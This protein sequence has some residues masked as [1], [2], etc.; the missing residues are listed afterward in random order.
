[1]GRARPPGGRLARTGRVGG[2]SLA[3]LPIRAG[4]AVPALI[5]TSLA[6]LGIVRLLPVEGVGLWLRLLVATVVALL[7]G[8][9]IGRAIGERGLAGATV[10]SVVAI[11]V[12]L[13]LA[14]L[15]HTTIDPGLW[16]IAVCS[17]LL[18]PF[19]LKAPRPQQR[20]RRYAPLIWV[21]A[22]GLLLGFA[23]WMASGIPAGDQLFH[24]ARV[25]KLVVL[26]GLSLHRLDEFR[27]GGLHPG[28]AF[29]LCTDSSRL[30]LAW[31]G[32][33]RQSSYVMKQASSHRS[34]R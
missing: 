30:C 6:F 14:F 7:P 19:G 9:L 1:M 3:H 31:P 11:G 4:L 23:I 18:L 16:L 33:I 17:L 25:R 15:W 27:D 21:A 20:R 32:P 13:V 22:V 26:D 29:P 10:W 12:A 2:L 8:A 28:Y 34:Q 24:M 5:V